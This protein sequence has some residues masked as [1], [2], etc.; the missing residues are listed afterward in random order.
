MKLLQSNGKLQW[1]T[2]NIVTQLLN[3]NMKTIIFHITKI[4]VF[5]V[6]YTCLCIT[7]LLSSFTQCISGIWSLTITAMT[8]VN[9][10]VTRMWCEASFQMAEEKSWLSTFRFGSWWQWIYSSRFCFS[11]SFC[12]IPLQARK[13]PASAREN[14]PTDKL[15]SSTKHKFQ[16]AAQEERQWS[17]IP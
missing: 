9:L 16:S 1:K 15:N 13:I 6:N 7:C 4:F 3:K 11:H 8:C 14:I 17:L 10:Y 12:Y 5:T 2:L